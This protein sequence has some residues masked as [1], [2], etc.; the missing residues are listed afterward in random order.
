VKQIW[1][2]AYDSHV[3]AKL[4]YPETTLPVALDQTAEKHPTHPFIIFKDTVLTYQE[5]HSAIQHFA[6]GLLDLGLK[7]G[8]RVAIHLP[9]CPQFIIAYY[10]VLRLGAIAVPCNPIYTVRELT[11][12]FND[13][14]ST[15]AITLSNTYPIIREIRS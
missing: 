10:A 9:N 5:T 12:Q 13:S 3:P 2:D 8:E 4:D 11:H 14:G 6:A 7:A 15:I 1:F